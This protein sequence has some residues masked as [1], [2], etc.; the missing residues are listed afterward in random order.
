MHSKI[1]ADFNLQFCFLVILSLIYLA[2]FISLGGLQGDPWWDEEFFWKTSLTFSERLFPTFDQLRN[3]EELNTPLPFII[4]GLLEYLFHGGIFVGRL[5]NFGLSFAI[6]LWIGWPQRQHRVRSLLSV[7]GLLLFPYYLWLSGLL[8]TDLIASFFGLLGIH[9]YRKQR[10][11]ISGLAFILA[12]ASRQYM[13]A[14][15]LGVVA[16]ELVSAY[17]NKTRLQW[18]ILAPVTAAAS[19][20]GWFILFQG[21]APAA[22]YASRL[23]PD[24]QRTLWA[25]T[26]GGG[27]YFLSLVG[28]YFVIPEFV[29]FWRGFCLKS[30]LQHRERYREYLAIA[31]GLL[32]LFVVFPPSLEASGN[33]IKVAGLLPTYALKIALFYSLALLAC[34]RFARPGLVFWILGFHCLIMMKAYQWD[35]YALPLLIVF[36]YLKSVNQLGF[37][38]TEKNVEDTAPDQGKIA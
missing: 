38:W 6:A 22:S 1:R 24:V 25:I 20:L 23:A 16:F 28:L 36:W 5:L 10:H 29:L 14:F 13:L 11:L 37:P 35:R 12:I 30:L 18:Q 2:L 9:F 32:I 26:P 17:R 33:L 21:F 15:P 34:L 8:Y 3:Y 27:L 7:V 4:Y 19:I 31:A